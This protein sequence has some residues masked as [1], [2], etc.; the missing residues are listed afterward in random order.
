M[1]LKLVP[2]LEKNPFG[3]CLPEGVEHF[4]LWAARE[5]KHEEVERETER[6]LD[7]MFPGGSPS[8]S[9]RPQWTAWNYWANPQFART[10]ENLPHFHILVSFIQDE[11]DVSVAGPPAGSMP[12]SI[13]P[14]QTESTSAAVDSASEAGTYE[15]LA[16]SQLTSVRSRD[17]TSALSSPAVALVSVEHL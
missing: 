5:L 2:F 6:L 3:Y 15:C 4:T 12:P 17:F 10:Y 16:S 7:E 1:L 8:G 13:R 9:G 14:Q 11:S